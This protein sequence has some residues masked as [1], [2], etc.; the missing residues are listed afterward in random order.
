MLPEG[1]AMTIHEAAMLLRTVR[2]PP[3]ELARDLALSRI[4]LI[5]AR[6]L[7]L[8]NGGTVKDAAK[9]LQD[10]VRSPVV[11]WP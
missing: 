2:A 10:V 3:S 11:Q 9:G 1:S 5:V 8:E 4:I 7:A 6:S